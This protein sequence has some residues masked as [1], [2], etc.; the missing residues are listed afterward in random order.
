MNVI[1][2][3]TSG[4]SNDKTRFAHYC[5]VKLLGAIPFQ[6]ESLSNIND[7]LFETEAQEETLISKKPGESD[8]KSATR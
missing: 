7:D 3:L 2:T 5:Y 8:V 1:K 4:L 6:N